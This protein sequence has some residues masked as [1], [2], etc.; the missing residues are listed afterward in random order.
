MSHWTDPHIIQNEDG[1]WTGFD[2]CGQDLY[3]SESREE[4]VST[5]ISYAK[6]LERQN[7]GISID[8]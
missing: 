8:Q 3:T 2:E 1:S 7:E 4:V 5:L 6:Y